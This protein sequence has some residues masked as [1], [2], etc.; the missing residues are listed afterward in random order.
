MF[1][2]LLEIGNF[3]SVLQLVFIPLHT[4]SLIPLCT[5]LTFVKF[6]VSYCNNSKLVPSPGILY[7]IYSKHLPFWLKKKKKTLVTSPVLYFSPPIGV[8]SILAPSGY[9]FSHACLSQPFSV[10]LDSLSF[11]F[12]SFFLIEV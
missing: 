9:S 6:S 12:F 5:S 2:N 11:F 8:T 3:A 1:H 10:K 7:H 4:S